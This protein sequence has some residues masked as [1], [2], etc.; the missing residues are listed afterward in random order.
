MRPTGSVA[1]LRD[2]A[3]K[4]GVAFM[5]PLEHS[6]RRTSALLIVS[7]VLMNK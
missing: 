2:Y 3:D 6:A 4:T 1:A 7:D 5:M